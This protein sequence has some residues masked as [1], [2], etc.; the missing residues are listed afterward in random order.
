MIKNIIHLSKFKQEKEVKNCE[1]NQMRIFKPGHFH[2]K[3]RNN[4]TQKCEN[5]EGSFLIYSS[6]VIITDR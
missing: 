1:E 4:N 5:K 6:R 2:K 3:S